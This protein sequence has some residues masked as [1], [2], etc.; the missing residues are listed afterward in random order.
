VITVA[1]LVLAA[2]A[3]AP[4]TASKTVFGSNG[5][6]TSEYKPTAIALAC[7]DAKLV[8]EDLE[9][10]QW[11]ESSAVGTGLQ[12]HPNVDD[13]SCARK[14]IIACPWVET[15][16]TVTFSRVVRCPSNGRW[17]FMH[18]DVVASAD[19]DREV[20]HEERDFSCREYAKPEPPSPP[21]PPRHRYW[22][23]CGLPAVYALNTVIAH[24]VPCGKARRLI[25]KVWRLGQE[26]MDPVSSLHVK[27]FDCTLN[28]SSS[29]AITCRRGS[30][31]VR[32]PLPG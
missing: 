26:Q 14:P 2:A 28:V 10:T 22:A 12:K 21:R 1:A 9:W 17:Q 7:A 18:M 29:R 3:A 6:W 19:V 32:G 5:C 8:V 13:P 23:N 25:R 11:D 24:K 20:R 27:S 30:H 15:E 16:A 31:V 4:A